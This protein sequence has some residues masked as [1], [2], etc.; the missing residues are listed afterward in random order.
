L[1]ARAIYSST[2]PN[3]SEHWQWV[4]FQSSA[5][6]LPITTSKLKLEL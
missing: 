6:R 3:A 5:F 1:S 4:R 2:E